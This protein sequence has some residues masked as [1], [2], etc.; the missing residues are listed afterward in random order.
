VTGHAGT[1]GP[2]REVGDAAHSQM[3]PPH[4]DENSAGAPVQ[5]SAAGPNEVPVLP[6]NAHGRDKVS[7]DDQH[8]RTDDESMYDRR[9]AEDKDKSLGEH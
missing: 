6:A 2:R 5:G 1:P 8:K 7:N 4:T 9:P 3:H